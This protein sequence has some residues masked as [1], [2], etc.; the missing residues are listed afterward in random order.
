MAIEKGHLNVAVGNEE[1]TDEELRQNIVMAINFFASLLK[2]QW[3]NL[4]A[5]NIKEIKGQVVKIL[6]KNYKCVR[7]LHS[8][9]D[10]PLRHQASPLLSRIR[11]RKSLVKSKVI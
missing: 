2:K 6:R 10:L 8:I 3:H 4:K 9:Q 11:A 5:I 1:M 7:I